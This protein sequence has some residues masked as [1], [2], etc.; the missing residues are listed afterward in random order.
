MWVGTG[1]RYLP[2]NVDRRT[3]RAPHVLTFR[4]GR[5]LSLSGIIR[6]KKDAVYSRVL[7]PN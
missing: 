3:E 5:P 6:T 4:K 1:G 7:P 2:V